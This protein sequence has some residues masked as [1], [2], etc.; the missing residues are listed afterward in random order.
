[1]RGLG[2]RG[3]L[4]SRGLGRSDEEANDRV[5]LNLVPNL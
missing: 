5:V 2:L 1:M 4:E 3:A